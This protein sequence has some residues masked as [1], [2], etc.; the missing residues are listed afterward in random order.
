[1]TCKAHDRIKKENQDLFELLRLQERAVV[2][3]KDQVKELERQNAWMAKRFV[4]HWDVYDSSQLEMR[5]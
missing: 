2:V 5:D 1:M 4:K 3:L